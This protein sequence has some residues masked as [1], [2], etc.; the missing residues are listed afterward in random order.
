MM[1]GIRSRQTQKRRVFDQSWGMPLWVWYLTYSNRLVVVAFAFY[2]WTEKLQRCKGK[3]ST[4]NLWTKIAEPFG[5][6]A[7]AIFCS[8]HLPRS[9]YKAYYNK[10]RFSEKQDVA[11]LDLLQSVRKK[12]CLGHASTTFNRVSVDKNAF[13]KERHVPHYMAHSSGIPDQF[14]S[15]LCAHWAAGAHLQVGKKKFIF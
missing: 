10:R 13:L 12:L 9:A 1:K 6:I 3:R 5:C 15:I 2:A 14:P 11:Y 7:S 4:L 8:V